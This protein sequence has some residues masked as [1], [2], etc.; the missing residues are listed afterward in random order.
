M[1]FE[2]QLRDRDRAVIERL[3]REDGFALV[4]ALALIVVF[5]IVTASAI[6]YTTTNQQSAGR[7]SADLQALQY[8]EA[9]LNGAYS[10]IVN[11]NSSGSDPTAA[12]LLGTSASPKTFCITSTS[13]VNASAGSASV[14]GC[15]GGTSGA[16]CAG[17]SPSAPA[18]TWVIVSQGFA[19]KPLG[20]TIGRSM[21]ATVV[22]SPLGSGQ[23]AAVWNHVFLTAPLVENVCQTTFGGNSM[24]IDV[25]L[26]VIGN[27]CVTG[28]SD[29]IKEVGQPVD[30]QVGGK[31]V[32]SGNSTVGVNA[33][34]PITSGVV[35]GGCT[36]ISVS[37]STSPCAGASPSFSYW[38]TTTD[39]FVSNIAPS[40]TTSQIQGDYDTFDPGPKHPC[41][42]GTNP[43]PLAS[44][45]FDNDTTYNSSAANFDLT[46]P[47]SY[48]CISQ[49]G[50]SAGYLIWNNGGSSITVS[51]ITVPSKTLAVNGS[52]FIDGDLKVTHSAT[53]V[54]TGVIEV[55]GSVTFTGNSTTLCATNP[56]NTAL[57]AWQGSSGN[58][59]MLTLASLISTGD[60]LRLKDNSQIFQGSVWTQPSATATLEGNSAVIEGPMSIGNIDVETNSATLK[61]LPVIKNM[62]VGAPIPPNTSVSI[63]ALTFIK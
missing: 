15:Y 40:Q 58:N 31:L 22:I 50:T 53:Y 26:Y 19:S 47:S 5:S 34:T 55:A 10:T 44:S 17:I 43:A 51:G 33:S 27:L 56:C 61:P 39:T 62:P 13:C 37:S 48:A 45:A 30:L 12:G 1:P 2:R 6:T 52:I 3:R 59:S 46:R 20:G 49:S 16:T 11:A 63:G 14:I 4:L 42:A 36:T 28:N 41:L 21:A 29:Q 60:A 38:V 7:S 25:P 35:V 18:S 23:V 57:N 24:V 8:A 32:L 54:G 9:G